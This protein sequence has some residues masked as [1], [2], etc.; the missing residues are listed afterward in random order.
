MATEIVLFAIFRPRIGRA[1]P[2]DGPGA[3]SRVG[4]GSSSP[5]ALGLVPNRTA[6]ATRF[7][8]WQ[9]THAWNHVPGLHIL[10]A[11]GQSTSQPRQQGQS[12]D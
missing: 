3:S 4:R 1:Q 6:R 7:G 10:S 5:T 11:R 9:T 12:P 2:L 8:V